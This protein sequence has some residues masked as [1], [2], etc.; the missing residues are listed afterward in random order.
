MVF[1]IPV[2]KNSKPAG[3]VEKARAKVN[4]ALNILGLYPDG[5]HQ[6][7]MIMQSL[8]LADSLKITRLSD[9]LELE[10]IGGQIEVELP[11]GSSNLAWQAARLLQTRFPR[12]ISGVRIELE[13]NIPVAA[14]L[15]GGSADAAAVL[16]GMNRLF[17]LQLSRLELEKLA[18]ELGM[19]VPFCIAGGTALARGR[20]DEL[21]ALPDLPA[22]QILLVNPG[23]AVSTAEVYNLF[24]KLVYHRPDQEREFYRKFL[25]ERSSRERLAKKGFEEYS[26][27][28]LLELIKNREAISWQEGWRNILQPITFRLVPELAELEDKLYASGA[29]HVQMTG[30]G[31]TLIAYF[32]RE[33]L[34][35]DAFKSWQGYEKLIP[36]RFS[37]RYSNKEILN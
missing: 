32:S 3:V 29:V 14:G 34:L 35:K 2:Q 8:S 37:S 25:K 12:R 9:G 16:R 13:K 21:Q 22:Q 36:A 27:D 20:G 5:Y 1:I 6:V 7:E 17:G 19:D 31:P 28:S 23:A 24:D 4:L 33:N 11:E 30:S 10:I 26:L 18:A 15:A